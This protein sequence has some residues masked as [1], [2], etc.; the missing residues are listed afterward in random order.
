[1]FLPT[2]VM[3]SPSTKK[4]AQ[5][6]GRFEFDSI[7]DLEDRFRV[8]KVG[9]QDLK[10]KIELEHLDCPN[11][12]A[13][14]SSAEDDALH[15]EIMKEILEEEKKKKAEEEASTGKKKGGK[16]KKK[17]KGKKKAKTSDL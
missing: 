14:G 1:M 2:I 8:G 4:Y 15:E 3:Y 7:K 13:E 10:D 16:K 11:V 17:G 6:I 9:A 12:V 5:L